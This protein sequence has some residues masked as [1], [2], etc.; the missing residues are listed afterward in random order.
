MTTAAWKIYEAELF[1]AG[2]EG[3]ELTIG[4]PTV[5]QEPVVFWKLKGVAKNITSGV[6]TVIFDTNTDLGNIATKGDAIKAFSK[7]D[8]AITVG[9]LGGGTIKGYHIDSA[10]DYGVITDIWWN[11]GAA[12]TPCYAELYT[13]ISESATNQVYYETGMIFDV[14][15][16]GYHLG[17]PQNQTISQPALIDFVGGDTVW[18]KVKIDISGTP[19][20]V[21]TPFHLRNNEDIGRIAIVDPNQRQRYY[22]DEISFS[23]VYIPYAQ[24]NN[25][26]S[27]RSLDTQRVEQNY[28]AIRRLVHLRDTLLAVCEFKTQPIYVSKDRVLSLDGSS[29]VGRTSRILN[30]A[31]E[32]VHDYGT[33]NPESVSYHDARIYAYDLHNGIV[34]RFSADG[35]TDISAEG[36]HNYFNVVSQAR[37][38]Y[39]ESDNRVISNIETQY[40]TVY[41]T[42]YSRVGS[43]IASFTEVYEDST[44]SKGWKGQVS[45]KP[46][47][48]GRVGQFFASFVNG[49]MWLHDSSVVATCNFYG[50]QYTAYIEFPHNAEPSSIKTPYRIIEQATDIWAVDNAETYPTLSYTSPQI[51]KIPSTR[52]GVF[53]GKIESEFL[54]NLKDPAQE[55]AV[56][57]NQQDREA[58]ALLRGEY[59][60]YDA[61]KIRL[62]KRNPQTLGTIIKVDI[63]FTKSENTI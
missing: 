49:E 10:G 30:I 23:G 42:F 5:N 36:K 37:R 21:P 41:F 15:S 45:F 20:L 18:S 31:Q 29:Q 51:S 55:F 4:A 2:I 1:A 28:G 16:S 9:N 8:T 46:E 12:P 50:V 59:L 52:F 7:V 24:Q 39:N 61:M 25:L 27:F 43:G 11:V 53:E 44:V 13:P 35:Q 33:M 48:Y 47:M 40:K 58:A 60:K 17:N 3:G 26:S 6:T 34:W 22:W 32:T 62:L 57:V 14:D 38:L 56:I 19:T 63:S 54:R